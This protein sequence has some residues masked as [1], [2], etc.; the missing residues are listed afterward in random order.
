[1]VLPDFRGTN[2]PITILANT[3]SLTLSMRSMRTQRGMSR[4]IC[5]KEIDLFESKIGRFGVEE[6]DDL[7]ISLSMQQTIYSGEV[8]L[9]GI[10]AKFKHMKIRYPFQARFWIRVGVIITT[11][12]FQSQFAE[13]PIACLCGVS[14]LY[15]FGYCYCRV[16]SQR[17]S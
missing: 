1:M 17:Q 10:N 3:T 9:T 15:R 14:K 2:A 4:T 11:K 6:P 8:Y 13:M 12:K 16:L 5:E 7:Q